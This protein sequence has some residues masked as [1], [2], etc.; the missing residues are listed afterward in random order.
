LARVYGRSGKAAMPGIAE[1]ALIKA[2]GRLGHLDGLR[3]GPVLVPEVEAL[4]RTVTC[5]SAAPEDALELARSFSA[6]AAAL[7][8]PLLSLTVSPTM[9]QASRKRNVVPALSAVTVHCRLL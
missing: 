6:L 1:K 2:A 3:P 9:I 8:E 4:L 7:V 5:R